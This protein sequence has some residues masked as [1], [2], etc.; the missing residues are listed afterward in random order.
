[1]QDN[2]QLQAAINS[3]IDAL[4]AMDEVK[5]PIGSA[6]NAAS[7]TAVE[8]PK[9][10]NVGYVPY[11]DTDDD[12]F[13]VSIPKITTIN[14]HDG[15]IDTGIVDAKEWDWSQQLSRLT[16]SA[17]SQKEDQMLKE[18][19]IELVVERMKKCAEC[20]F[21]N[22][23]HCMH[24]FKNGKQTSPCPCNQRDMLVYGHCPRFMLASIV[25]IQ[26]SAEGID[27]GKD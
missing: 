27:D 4:D 14:N 25:E 9:T 15:W 7:N 11:S 19:P 24:R 5:S 3:A 12:S 22:A 18:M 8:V 10:L 17:S 20:T 1:M 16:T 6:T 23:V 21:A 26:L 2:K 13:K